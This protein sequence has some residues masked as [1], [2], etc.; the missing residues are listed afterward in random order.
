[1]S[2]INSTNFGSPNGKITPAVCLQLGASYN[3]HNPIFCG[4]PIM[5]I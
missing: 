1:L 3:R 2:H 5:Q 4:N